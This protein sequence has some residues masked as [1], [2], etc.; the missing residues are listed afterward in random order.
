MDIERQLVTIRTVSEIRPILGADNIE[1]AIVD[2]WQCCV[3]KGEFKVGNSGLYFEIDSFIPTGDPRF[4]FLRKDS[5]EWNGILG[6]RIR[7][8][9][10][11][12][13]ISQGLL[14]PLGFFPEIISK[15][16]NLAELLGITKWERGIPEQEIRRDSWFD[17]IIR[18]LVPK[19]YR[20][21]V[22]DFIYTHFKNRK[23][24]GKSSF[25]SFIPK[26]DEER[27]Q[28][29]ISKKL[30]SIDL[31]EVT[32]KLN[33]SSMTV[34][35]KDGKF[36]H[37]SRNIKLGLEDGSRFSQAV[38]KY[39]LDTLPDLLGNINVAIQGELCG[40]GIQ[41]NYE[42][43]DELDFFVFR[44]WDIDNQKYFSPFDRDMFLETLWEMGIHLKKVPVL[45]TVSLS[46]FT[47]IEDYLNYA[48]GPSFK[49]EKR[50]GVVFQ[51]LDGLDSFKVISNSY[52][53]NGG[54]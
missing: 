27:I 33:G 46:R 34:F 23:T 39:S 32:T 8:I 21:T 35:T 54:D 17:P 40:P 51:K 49:A 38:K 6:T 43:L 18:F 37:C 9:K 16:K 4:E 12:G 28:N 31:Y 41:G 15:D 29:V 5:R 2:G 36:G 22:F 11:R 44:I 50:E 26:T 7:T 10:L 25:P 48:E 30:G 13:Q 45:E 53:L 19:Q 47:S 3:K 1:L 20:K 24:K 52:L 42:K 14:L